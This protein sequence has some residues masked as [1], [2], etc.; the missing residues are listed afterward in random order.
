MR[1]IDADG[2]VNDRA[3]MDELAKYMPRGN[4]FAPS[5]TISITIS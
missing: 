3:C 1:I 2:H 5:S 4:R